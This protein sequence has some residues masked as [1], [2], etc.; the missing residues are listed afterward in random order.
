MTSSSVH[1]GQIENE[2]YL[3]ECNY[4]NQSIIKQ[5]VF[6]TAVTHLKLDAIYQRQFKGTTALL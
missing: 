2:F 6:A 4:V 5:Q 1:E 3:A